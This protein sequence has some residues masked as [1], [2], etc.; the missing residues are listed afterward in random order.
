VNLTS[1]IC[2]KP[3]TSIIFVKYAIRLASNGVARRLI[4]LYKQVRSGKNVL[5]PDITEFEEMGLLH[6]KS[7]QQLQWE[8]G[9]QLTWNT[10]QS[11][12]WVLKRGLIPP[13]I[14]K[15]SS[16]VIQWL[17]FSQNKLERSLS[18]FIPQGNLKCHNIAG[19]GWEQ[20]NQM[21]NP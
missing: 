4:V 14:Y 15:Y 11:L 18:F 5:L 3:Q 20:R 9:T 19:Q 8:R 13:D 1:A 21:L 17:V 6:E 2:W 16:P 7:F 10:F 12:P